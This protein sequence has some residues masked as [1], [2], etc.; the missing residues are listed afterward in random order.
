ML[1]VIMLSVTSFNC[2]AE[3][4]GALAEWL[5]ARLGV[6]LGWIPALFPNNRQKW[7]WMCVTNALAYCTKLQCYYFTLLWTITLLV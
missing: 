5:Q 6:T 1:R 3:C 4:R 2:Y 7:K